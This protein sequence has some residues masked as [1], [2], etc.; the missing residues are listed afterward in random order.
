[1]SALER[2]LPT[3]ADVQSDESQV[4]ALFADTDTIRDRFNETAH[5][6]IDILSES[7]TAAL[8]LTA[9][10]SEAK[11]TTA[12]IAALNERFGLQLPEPHPL[13]MTPTDAQIV[14]LL[15]QLTKGALPRE[16]R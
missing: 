5:R 6:L 16:R 12:K 15:G 13:A 2:Q 9:A 11:A 4:R 1:M 7:E 3:A 14:Y 8:Y 10:H